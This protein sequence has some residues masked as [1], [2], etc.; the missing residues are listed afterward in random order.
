MIGKAAIFLKHRSKKF[1]ELKNV[2]TFLNKRKGLGKS[3]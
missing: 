3:T 2:K 1:L